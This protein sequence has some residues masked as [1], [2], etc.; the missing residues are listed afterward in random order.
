MKLNT[1][2]KNIES[3]GMNI[4]VDFSIDMNG[5]AFSV[6]SDGMYSEIIPTIVRELSSNAYDSHVAAGKA[7]VPFNVSCPSAFDPYFAVQDFGTGL[8]YYRYEGKMRN[9]HEG[10][11]TIFIPGDIRKKIN[12]INLIVLN[13]TETTN[14]GAVLYDNSTDET[15][16]RIA[17]DWDEG[18][19]IIE[20]DDTLVLYSTYFRSTKEQS[21]DYI[22]AFG[23]GSKTPLAYTDN[24]IVIN[25]F[26]GTERIYNILTNED[27]MPQINLM[28]SA[29]TT[30]PNGLEVK[31]AVS[32]DDYK[33]FKEAIVG[34]LKYFAPQPTIC[35]DSV[36]M[37]QPTYVGETFM[38][39]EGLESKGT[40]YYSR[41]YA[42]VGNN[43]Y[44]I[45]NVQ[46]DLFGNNL[47]L[48]FNVG[49]VMVTASREELKYDQETIKNIKNREAEAIEEYT[50]YV[51]DTI[52]TEDMVDYEKAEFLNKNCSVINLNSDR[53]KKL[54]GNP[55]YI[56]NKNVITIPISGWGD[57]SKISYDEY[58]DEEGNTQIRYNPSRYSSTTA[59]SWSS[60]NRGSRKSQKLGGGMYIRPTQTMLVFIRD[61]SYSFLKKI[62]Y[63]MEEKVNGLHY[64]NIYVL[65]L[66]S[67]PSVSGIALEAL[68]SLV[69]HTADF[70]YL[71][72]IELPKNHFS[73]SPTDRNPTPIA[74]LF[75]PKHHSFRTTKHWNDIYT[76]LTKIE[77][78][79]YIV[80]TH[81]CTIQTSE[82]FGYKDIRFLEH[83]IEGGF[84][85]DPDTVILALP[86]ARYEKALSY[87]FK[88][89]KK[90]IKKLRKKVKV[91]VDLMNC[92]ALLDGLTGQDALDTLWNKLYYMSV[93][94]LFNAFED[95]K[96]YLDILDKDNPIR[97]LLRVRRIVQNRYYEKGSKFN[98]INNLMENMDISAED[99][100]PSTY[101]EDAIDKYTEMCD[102]VNESTVLLDG[103]RSYNMTD[104][105]KEAFLQYINMLYNTGENIQ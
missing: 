64:D 83:Y 63:Y 12:G 91:P 7:D 19:I 62:N 43:A 65:D 46:S 60:Y 15:V 70:V 100:K 29:E 26:D 22:G 28:S 61:N 39:Y 32:P 25:R 16:I 2:R 1:E 53:V 45:Q 102:N 56:Y 74:R 92:R 4:N 82:K 13:D 80:E 14:I 10:E 20:F 68:R 55:N 49:E 84:E 67:D 31:I 93:L 38:I 81:R 48:K 88:P 105:K 101:L 3:Y 35:N 104:A 24:F 95:E 73:Y 51:L 50:A 76:P 72:S 44:E 96:E 58:L 33:E 71:S 94:D 89:V 47:V 57:Y 8:K 42:C 103:I 54:V 86:R 30:E 85:Y 21:N 99:L 90:L 11:S 5:K 97:T 59:L 18:Q 40:G 36:I 75:D 87:G 23:L 27:G 52:D 77:K 66:F 78:G 79:A 34:Q 17:G 69:D 9:E 37:P 98:S 6:L 41:S